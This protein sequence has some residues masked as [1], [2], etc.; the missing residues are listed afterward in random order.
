[1]SRSPFSEDQLV[2]QPAIALFADLGWDTVN[3]YTETLGSA[4][5]LGRDHQGDV[6]LTRP[7]RA[8]LGRFNPLLPA[9]ALD[10]AIEQ[11]MVDRSAMDPVRANKE[12][13]TL[14]RDGVRVK[15]RQDDGSES[16]E[17]VRVSARLATVDQVG[18]VQPA[19]R[20]GRVRE[21]DPARVR[22]VESRPPARARRFRSQ[23]P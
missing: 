4:G 2:E 11:L 22:R 6:I 12:L 19:C 5:T 8:A 21:W 13:Y 3:A 23:H 15:V 18:P 16:P 1:M 14:L 17:L 7:L 20:S 10:S 9:A